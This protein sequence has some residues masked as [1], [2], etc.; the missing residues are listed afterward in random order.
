MLKVQVLL[1]TSI[2]RKD[3]N[4]MDGAN[5]SG[6]VVAIFYEGAN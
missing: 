1:L 5:D 2:V 3:P 4:I 6:M